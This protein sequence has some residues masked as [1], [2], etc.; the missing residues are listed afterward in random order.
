MAK[1]Q[2][3]S[4]IIERVERVRKRLALN[5]SRFSQSIGMR[6]QTY[7]NFVGSQGSKPN[8]ELICGLI[9]VYN[10][11]PDWLLTG[12]GDIFTTD[13]PS[14]GNSG[15]LP[16]A[17]VGAKGLA[18][19]KFLNTLRNQMYQDPVGALR[20]IREAVDDLDERISQ[21]HGKD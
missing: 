13:P 21:A 18:Q 5:K 12:S 20:A 16:N 9:N 2:K 17:D 4:E 10:V 1:Q 6:P 14:L 3:F 7:N 15:S 19:R 8:I 11:N